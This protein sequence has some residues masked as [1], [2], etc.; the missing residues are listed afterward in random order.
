MSKLSSHHDRHNRSD[1]GF[2]LLEVLLAFTI[3]T[4]CA[5]SLA[6]LGST[7]TTGN[8]RSKDE[9]AAT[10]LAVHKI[11]EVNAT[12]WANID[13]ECVNDTGTLNETAGSGGIFTRTC[14]ITNGTISGVSS[15]DITVSVNWVGGGTVTLTTTVVNVPQPVNGYPYAYVKS[16]D[17]T[18]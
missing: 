10:A 14:Q 4:I 3:L 2:T 1:G 16:W 9:A 18:G 6:L 11:E 8:Y 12:V 5:A 17:Q 15:K 13:T 7:T